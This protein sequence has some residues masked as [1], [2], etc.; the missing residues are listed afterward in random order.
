M[1]SN[2][3]S[4]SAT[5]R[6]GTG[7]NSNEP[8]PPRQNQILHHL[9]ILQHETRAL[10][11]RM[12]HPGGEEAVHGPPPVPRMGGP[13]AWRNRHRVPGLCKKETLT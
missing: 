11:P 4:A 3:K 1:R 10:R 8:L 7:G 6:C 13:W 5:G 9:H 12:R 2:S